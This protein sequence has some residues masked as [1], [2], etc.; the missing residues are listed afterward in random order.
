MIRW[1]ETAKAVSEDEGMRNWIAKNEKSDD[2]CNKFLDEFP[3]LNRGT[4]R[5]RSLAGQLDVL[6]GQ[7]LAES[8]RLSRLLPDDGNSHSMPASMSAPAIPVPRRPAPPPPVT[9]PQSSIKPDTTE[10]NT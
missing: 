1:Q 9:P 7:A 5:L 4:S 10:Q 2:F 3:D 8:G 6:T